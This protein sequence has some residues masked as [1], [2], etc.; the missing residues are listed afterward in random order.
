MSFWINT[1]MIKSWEVV[2]IWNEILLTIIFWWKSTK[3]LYK[4]A[5][6]ARLEMPASAE[7]EMMEFAPIRYWHGWKGK[8]NET[9]ADVKPLTHMS[10]E[11]NALREDKVIQISLVN[12]VWKTHQKQDGEYFRVRKWLNDLAIWMSDCLF[13]QTVGRI[14][15]ISSK[16]TISK[17]VENYFSTAFWYY[18]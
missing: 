8:L 9:T 10:L 18:Y 2:M 5:H 17:A 11:V 13:L 1:W 3:K 6:L 7:D 15:S 16:I 12:K 14:Q 4:I